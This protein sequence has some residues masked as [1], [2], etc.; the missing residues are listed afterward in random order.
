M[1]FTKEF[2]K[3]VYEKLEN[4]GIF[5]QWIPLH[6]LEIYDYVSIIKTL[7]YVFSNVTILITGIYTLAISKKGNIDRFEIISKEFSDLE[8]IG[9][10]EENFKSLVFLS[11]ELSKILINKEKGEILSD[12][13]SSVEFAEFHRR[14]AENTTYKNI[15]LIL[16]YSTPIE[17]SKFTGL[18]PTKHYSMILS[19]TA[20][21]E[22]W[23]NHHYNALKILD[24]SLELNPKNFYSKFLFSQ[25]FPEFINL[26]YKYQDNIKSEYG[27]KTYQELLDYAQKKLKEIETKEFSH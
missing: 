24:K 11:P 13:R 9:I 12:L 5:A 22:Y 26:L 3:T 8:S 2:Y 19:K 4:D 14:V 10:N 20:L 15:K 16:K 6:N 21:I 1:L 25:I 18:S 17:L 23:E 7:D 27:T